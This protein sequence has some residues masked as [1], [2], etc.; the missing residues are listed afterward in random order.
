MVG[1]EAFIFGAAKRKEI[2]IRKWPLL[3]A[4]L[5]KA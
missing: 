5:S 2:L 4:V 3:V 1:Y